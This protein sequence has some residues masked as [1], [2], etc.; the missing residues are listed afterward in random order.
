MNRQPRE[1]SA[2]ILHRSAFA[3]ALV[4]LACGERPVATTKD[5]VGRDVALPAK[6][7][8][9]VALSPNLTEMLYA[10]GAGDRLV[11]ADDFSNHPAAARALPKVGGM[12]PNIEKIAALRPDLVLA[13]NEGNHPNLAPALAAAGIPL[14][15]VGTDRVAEVPRAMRRLAAMLGVD[16]GRAVRELEAGLAAQKRTRTHA[17]RVLFAVWTDPLFVAGRET[18]TDDLLQLTGAVNA[19]EV[20]GWP[21]YSL[22]SLVA[23]PPDLILYPRSSVTRQQVDALRARVPDV[24][25]EI[26]DVDDDIFQRPGPRVVDAARALNAILDGRGTMNDER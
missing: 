16:A 25:A 10:I 26:I 12:Q 18:F 23:R 19:V 15:V 21:Q 9:I 8:R 5:D 6:L 7:T 14:F 11:G 1:R 22:E 2:F 17:P 13:S 4:V 20:P 3:L 24:Q